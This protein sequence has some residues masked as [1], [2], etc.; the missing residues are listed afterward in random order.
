MKL[1]MGKADRI[2]RILLALTV[3]YL[4][5]VKMISGTLGIVLMIIAFIFLITG[6]VGSC[7]L[8]TLFGIN[9]RR[10]AH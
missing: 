10:H 3:G 1:N 7:P 2:I 4:Y 9:S 8:Y 6:I 5:Y